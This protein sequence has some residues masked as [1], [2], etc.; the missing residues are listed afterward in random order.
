M[1][2]SL[3]ADLG[4]MQG[5]AFRRI[6]KCSELVRRF[7]ALK[8][9][10]N[11]RSDADLIW[12]LYDWLTAPLTLW[13]IDF[14]GLANHVLSL[15]KSD[16]SS[17]EQLILLLGLVGLPP[18][19]TAQKVIERFEHDIA[20]GRYEELVLRQEKYAELENR[21]TSDSELKSAWQCIR[22]YFRIQKF[23][24]ERGV[25]RRRMSQER[26]F[27]DGWD[28]DWRSPKKRFMAI[29]DALCYRWDLYG[30]QGDQPLLLKVS[31]PL[32]VPS[33][34]YR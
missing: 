27:R 30:F 29:F 34:P 22:K 2:R 12:N 1:R 20:K 17:D 13:P 11:R 3:K 6:Q 23:Q 31:W 21:L 15:V 4:K 18:G 26:N 19:E 16:H 7:H 32:S 28:F 33:A 14:E 25:I 9:K 24:N 5:Y 8:K 10:I